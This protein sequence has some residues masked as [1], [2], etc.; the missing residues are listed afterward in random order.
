MNNSA[1]SDCSNGTLSAVAQL[2]QF[3]MLPDDRISFVPFLTREVFAMSIHFQ[4]SMFV[5]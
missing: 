4:T 2:V 5:L 1:V 3:T